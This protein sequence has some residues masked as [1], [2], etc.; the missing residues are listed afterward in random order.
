MV[1]V[2]EIWRVFSQD[3]MYIL[4]KYMVKL[5]AMCDFGFNICDFKS[6]ETVVLRYENMWYIA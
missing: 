6:T 3:R 2:C 5:M 1:W 4:W